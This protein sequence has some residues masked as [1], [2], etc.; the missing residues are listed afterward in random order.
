MKPRYLEAR[1]QSR[2]IVVEGVLE[3]T[4]Q[5]SLSAPS[6]WATT[7]SAIVRDSISDTPILLGSTLAGLLR[8]ALRARLA[9]PMR[10]E[11]SG[12][13]SPLFGDA[14]DAVGQS[15]LIV[16]D[17]LA[18][19]AAC[20]TRDGIRIDGGSG[21]VEEGAKF[22]LEVL[23]VGTRFP[24]RLELVLGGREGDD[25]KTL[26]DFLTCLGALE[27]GEVRLGGRTRRGFGRCRVA[28]NADG[29]RW[30][31]WDFELG[32]PGGLL[33]WLLFDRVGPEAKTGSGSDRAPTPQPVAGIDILAARLGSEIRRPRWE[34]LEIRALLQVTGSMLVGATTHDPAAADV[35]A[36]QRRTSEADVLEEFLPGTSLA[37]VMRHRAVKIVRTLAPRDPSAG[38]ELVSL[39]F[40]PLHGHGAADEV[41]WAGLLEVDDARITGGRILRH[42]RVS[43]DGWTGGARDHLLFEEDALFNGTAEVAMRVQLS[44]VARAE[45]LAGLCI[46]IFRDLYA[47]DLPIGRGSSIGRGFVRGMKG[48]LTHRPEGGGDEKKWTLGAFDP[49][50]GLD[51]QGE[52][53]DELERWVKAF[54]DHIGFESI[55]PAGGP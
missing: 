4:S 46:C 30:S 50:R 26:Q 36:I 37:G 19:H 16:D 32:T 39:L 21:V 40:G 5:T 17:S 31:V 53:V 45:A 29:A 23:E 15:A 35:R 41:P 12:L 52:S 7:D 54:L 20:A 55:G 27:A 51:A 10:K 44:G 48:S 13:T 11:A 43:I 1:P 49:A 6:S 42:S 47:G 25:A 14:D 3:L 22:D 33:S 34:Q 8:H 2:R 38:L 9:G 18:L 28:P 24:I